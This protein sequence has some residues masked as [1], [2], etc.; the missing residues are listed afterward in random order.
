[1][2]A[3]PSQAGAC[4]QR[5]FGQRSRVACNRR[6]PLTSRL[7][8]RVRDRIEQRAQSPMVIGRPGV[9]RDAAAQRSGTWGRSGIRKRDADNAARARAQLAGIGRAPGVLVV[10][11]PTKKVSAREGRLHSAPR[12]FI[13]A[14]T[15]NANRAGAQ[16]ERRADRQL[17]YRFAH[18]V[19][20]GP[21]LPR[22][23]ASSIAA[24]S[25]ASSVS[26]PAAAFSS[27]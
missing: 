20:S 7:I 17:L 19:A 2:L 16:C 22:G 3:D 5:P 12:F 8:D 23:N 10:I 1:M 15:R 27:T 4:R 9:V 24:M 25:P 6:H 21:G 11:A 13:R 14:R 26:D 18:N